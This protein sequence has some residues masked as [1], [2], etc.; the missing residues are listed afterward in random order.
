MS[1]NSGGSSATFGLGV[2][3]GV[4]GGPSL[5]AAQQGQGVA[6][7]L[8]MLAVLCFIFAYCCWGAPFC[9]SLCRR[10]C[11]CRLEDP[12]PDPRFGS[13]DQAMVATPT[14]ILLP[15]GRMLVVDGTIFTQFQ[16]DT[17]GLDLVELG[18]SVIRAQ[19]T[20]RSVNRHQLQSSQGSILEM[21]AETPSKD[22]LGSLGCFPPP[23]YES[24]YGKEESDMPPSYSDILL[25][26]FANLPYEIEMQDFGHEGKEEIEMQTLENCPRVIS[27]PINGIRFP[28]G[29]VTSFSSESFPQQTITR[30]PSIISNPLDDYYTDNELNGYRIGNFR[31]ENDVGRTSHQNTTTMTTTTTESST[32]YQDYD[33]RTNEQRNYVNDVQDHQ[34]PVGSV[35]NETMNT[36]NR[37]RS[38]NHDRE[39]RDDGVIVVLP[40]CQRYQ[41]VNESSRGRNV[42]LES[43]EDANRNSERGGGSSADPESNNSADEDAGDFGALADIRESRV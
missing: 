32:C 13:S 34:V 27:N 26:R 9:R 31:R 39:N 3:V 24:I 11:C 8:V 7:L 5:A 23:T 14:I 29:T 16:A 18:E 43:N 10:H 35:D 12:E 33:E 25:H 41:V 37:A 20:P 1:S 6:A 4:A 2:G 30:N 19:R 15:H 22:S 40:D 21:D 42:I 38:T 36:R 17:T 28:Y